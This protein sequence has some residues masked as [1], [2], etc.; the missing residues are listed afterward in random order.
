MSVPESR[1]QRT[2]LL[3]YQALRMDMIMS[4]IVVTHSDDE[5]KSTENH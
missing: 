2:F 3:Q 1:I 4:A 5:E